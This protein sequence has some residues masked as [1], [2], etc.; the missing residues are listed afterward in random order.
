MGKLKQLASDTAIYG[1]SSIL[2]RVLSYLLVSF[3]TDIFAEAQY[4]IVTKLYAYTAFF[5]VICT[6][7]M[8]TA[9]FRYASRFKEKRDFIFYQA[10]FYVIFLS[11]IV[12]ALVFFNATAVVNFL[13]Y[14][15]REQLVQWLAII[16]FIDAVVAI[17]FARIRLENRP[18]FFALVRISSIVLTVLLNLFF[19]YPLPDLAIGEYFTFLQPVA[20]KIY[21][22]ELGVGYIFLANL[23]GNSI[24]V[25]F[26]WKYLLALRLNIPWK[27]LQPMLKYAIPIVIIGMAG[28][29]NEQLDK[30]LLEELWPANLWGFSGQEA[31]GIYGACFKLSVFMLLAIQAFRYAAEPF[32]FSNAQDKQAPELFARVMYYFVLLSL[33]I[34]VAVSLNVDL[35][36]FIFLRQE[37]YRV[38]LFVVPYLLLGKL[39]FGVYVN[40]S[41][42][43]KITDK[44]LYGVYFSVLGAIITIVGNILLIPVI[45]FLGSAITAIVAYLGMSMACYFV[46]Q[47]HFKVPYNVKSIATQ[48]LIATVIVVIFFNIKF[49]NTFVNYAI[50]LITSFTYLAYLFITERNKLKQIVKKK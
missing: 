48:V 32:F 11:L 34:F 30:I 41:I 36:G 37:G 4:G 18:K 47:K 42:W 22:P 3:H 25:I 27:Q 39:F 46:G 49:E 12:T 8:E 33:V 40:L 24:M 45:G 31:L 44:T 15:G 19:L 28:I 5:N 13:D 21:N 7:G 29:A 23:I 50:G 35:I 9:F 1:V 16:I 17:P 2:G 26:L 10:N 6:F 43:Y 14:P 38:G 20:E